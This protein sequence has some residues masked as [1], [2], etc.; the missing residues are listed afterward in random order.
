MDD[1][2]PWHF[3][4]V[5]SPPARSVL[6]T[7]AGDA[8][9]KLV[10]QGEGSPR[11]RERLLALRPESL[12]ASPVQ[13]L[14]DARAMLAGMW[15][16]HDWLNESHVISQDIASPTG[17]FWHAI[18]HRR[19]RDFSNAKYWYARCRHHPALEQIAVLARGALGEAAN[20][21]ALHRLTDNG[22]DPGGFVDVVEATH[23][24]PSDPLY[25]TAVRLQRVEWQALFEYCARRAA[26][27]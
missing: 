8:Y 6:E 4:D 24:N 21:A 22:W 18:M 5:L 25:R 12:L 10:V 16:W 7:D 14:E 1:Q 26:G 3:L 20:T 19:E 17:S 15:L 9:A 23:R 2:T 27:Q 11:V 13:S